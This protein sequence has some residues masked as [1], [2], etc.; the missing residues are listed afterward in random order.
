MLRAAAFVVWMALAGAVAAQP[1][2]V[3]SDGGDGIWVLDVASGE[4]GWC[5]L[6]TPPGAKLIDVFGMDSQ[7]REARPGTPRPACETVRAGN[8]APGT[9]F[10]VAAFFADPEAHGW[11][12]GDL[13][14]WETRGDVGGGSH[15]GDVGAVRGR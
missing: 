4:V 2:Q 9:P 3:V 13:R 1:F 14:P 12:E 5:R 7:V 6:V 8:G 15:R 10:D 11:T